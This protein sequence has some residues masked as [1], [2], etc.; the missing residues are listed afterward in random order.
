M[1]ALDAFLP[2]VMPALA[3]TP[4]DALS[5]FVNG[6]AGTVGGII[7]LIIGVLIIVLLVAAAIVLIPAIA[8]AFLVWLVTG[9]LFF[10]GIAFLVV[11]VIS[12]FAM[13]D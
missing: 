11:A 10:A 2:S 13:A 4:L 3:R 6:M 7:L 12:I 1:I 5:S 8:V 9:S